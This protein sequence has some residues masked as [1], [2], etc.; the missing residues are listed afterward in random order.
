M[1]DTAGIL[2]DKTD[3][4]VADEKCEIVEANGDVRL[5]DLHVWQICPQAHVAINSV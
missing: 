5:M 4:H 2:L 1:H 3:K